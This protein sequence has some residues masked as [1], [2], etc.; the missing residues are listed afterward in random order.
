[1]RLC[2]KSLCASYAPKKELVSRHPKEKHRA[3]AQKR[4]AQLRM[5]DT[6]DGPLLPV[7]LAREPCRPG[8][9]VAWRPGL[10]APGCGSPDAGLAPE[11]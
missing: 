1:M 7:A 2:E 4:N 10:V 5:S 6:T 9:D 8:R 3:R 11:G